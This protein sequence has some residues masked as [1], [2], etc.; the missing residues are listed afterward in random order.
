MSLIYFSSGTFPHIVIF[1]NERTTA[2]NAP[3]IKPKTPLFAVLLL[4]LSSW[5]LEGIDKTETFAEDKYLDTFPTNNCTD[6]VATKL[7][8]EPFVD[9]TLTEKRRIAAV[10]THIQSI[11]NIFAFPFAARNFIV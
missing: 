6:C 4:K 3:N 8:K 2:R 7:E 1:K 9:F 11:F 10:L 5:E